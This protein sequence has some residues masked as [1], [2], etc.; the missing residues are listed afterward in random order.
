MKKTNAIDE[1]ILSL[2]WHGYTVSTN[3]HPKLIDPLS[4]IQAFHRRIFPFSFMIKRGEVVCESGSLQIVNNKIC[5]N[6]CSKFLI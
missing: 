3:N 5:G 2:I 1:N 4:F 6:N